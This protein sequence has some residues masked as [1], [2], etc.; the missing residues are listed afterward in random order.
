MKRA[1]F[2][3]RR[4]GAC[5]F[6]LFTMPDREQ[7]TTSAVAPPPAPAATKP[8]PSTKPTPRKLP[9]YN[10]VLLDD[11]DHTYEYVIEMLGA[12]FGHPKEKGFQLAKEVD[13]TGRVIVMTT[14]KELA[15]HKRDQILAHGADPRLERCRGSMSAIVEAAME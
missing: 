7:E 5:G 9:P 10:V 11:D 14:H 6:L 3:L 12:I 13:S 1:N 8:A 15:E 4:R 2:R